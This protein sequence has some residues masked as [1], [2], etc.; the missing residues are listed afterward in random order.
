MIQ[1]RDYQAEDCDAIMHGFAGYR[2]LLLDYATGM[3]KTIVA[4]ET[5][6][7]FL[8]QRCLFIC[9]KRELIEQAYQKIKMVTGI[10][11]AREMG[12][13][14]CGERGLLQKAP[15]IVATIQTLNSA[16]GD[17]RRMHRFNPMDFGLV[18]LDE[19]HH[20]AA[21]SYLRFHGHM[22]VNP[23][24]KELGLTAT[25]DR[26]DG[27][28]IMDVIYDKVI[29]IRDIKYGT[30]NG[31]LVRISQE[32]VI[33]RN[34][35]YSGIHVRDGD[36]VPK[37]LEAVLEQE[38]VVQGMVHPSLEIIFAV[39]PRHQLECIPQRD[40]PALLAK[41]VLVAKV[42][43]P[44]RTIFFS[45]SV[46][47]A[48]MAA[49]IFNRVYPGL[50]EFVSYR[51]PDKERNDILGRFRNGETPVICNAGILLEGFDEPAV[52]VILVGQPTLSRPRYQQMAGRVTRVL[53]GVVDGIASR[54]ERLARIKA[55]DKQVG[56][57]IDYVGNS[58]R[59]DIVTAMHIQS[60]GYSNDEVALA[61]RNSRA[62]NKP[63]MPLRE[64]E[65]ARAQLAKERSERAAKLKAAEEAR[66]RGIWAKVNYVAV[67]RDPYQHK[68][69]GADPLFGSL[70]ERLRPTP[71]QLKCLRYSGVDGTRFT[72]G[73]CG[74]LIS[75]LKANNYKITE[76]L[77]EL[78]V[79]FRKRHGLK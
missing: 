52:E 77:K 29:A 53:P 55:S 9:E 12:G 21:E 71:A 68:S 28:P 63:T 23:N 36:F 16:W 19:T 76:K 8:P 15:I 3:G 41:Q 37:E 48:E 39:E 46:A 62:K 32:Q 72:R 6:R 59:H 75:E 17:A 40:W 43:V 50:A 78:V 65:E 51:T 47:Q 25:R 45:K 31:W 20:A 10:E 70:P 1:M 33:V 57:L 73:Q 4:A 79:N 61:L 5:I 42:K 69:K 35:D 27:K 14:W 24:L 26:H 66:R 54:E 67:E 18:I 49:T 22:K 44:R 11:P 56:R 34:L 74:Q 13:Y 30:E 38:A 58:A 60:Q 7:R 2:A 64:L